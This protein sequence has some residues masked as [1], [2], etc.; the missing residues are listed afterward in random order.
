M[1]QAQLPRVQYELVTLGGGLDLV[2]PSL[3][4]APG[5]ARSAVNFECSITG[6]YTRVAGYERFD[7]RTSPSDATYT[8]LTAAITGSIVAGNTITGAT[9]G[10]T[11]VVFLVS[12]STVAFTKATGTFTAGETIRVGGVGQGTVTALG[13]ATPLTSQQSAQ[14]LNLA[15]DVYRADIGTVPGSGPVRGVA[16]YSGTVYAWRNNVGATAL[17][18]YK[19][20]AS[21]WTLVSYGF[22]MSFTHGTIALVDGNTITGQTSGATATIKRVVLESGSW[23]GSDAAGRLIFA[24]V[25]GTFQAGEHLRIGSTTYAHA[26]AAQTAIT[27]LPSGRVETVVAN[28]GGNVNTTRLYGCDGVNRAFEFD[29]VQQVYVPIS[30]GMADDRP[31][32][33]AFHKSHLFLSFGSSVQHSAIGDPYVWDPVFG[34]GEIALID[35]VTSFL[36]LPGDQ[37]TGAMAIYADDNTFMLY[38]TSSSD[39]NLVSYNVG[40]GAKP[41]SAQNLVSSFAF[42]DRGIMNLKTTLN[43]GNFDASALTLNIR[44]FVQQRRNKV[45]ASGVNREKSQYRVFFSDGSGIYATLFNGKYMGSM[46]VEFPDAVNCMCDGEDPDGSETAFFG[47]TDG[48]VYRLD[49]GTSFDGD[50]IGASIIL[51]YGFAK[52]PRILKRW[53]RASL[54]IDGNAYA[55]FSFSYSLAYGSTLVPQGAQESYST[56]LSASFWDNVNWDS[57]VWDGRTLAPSE[58]EVVGTGENI[59]VHV[60]CNSDYYAPFTINSVILHYSMRRGLR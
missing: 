23:S 42:D 18:M 21:G 5:V 53:R 58:V 27:A 11:G 60:A 1:Q 2:T 35:N 26:V 25:T 59:A 49:V 15:A 48:R 39:W 3:S 31:N 36:V 55:E 45:T 37:S 34:A 54:E 17:A 47:S 6:G 14:Y 57:F 16:Y 52:S 44:P 8:T 9:S 46:P 29:F 50:E 19:S 20:S 24:S 12:G 13:P 30:T 56:N 7:G 41:Y 33:I 32:H 40:T 22:E 51:T 28:F 43:Y 4:L 10:A 38:G